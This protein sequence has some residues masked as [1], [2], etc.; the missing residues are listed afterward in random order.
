MGDNNLLPSD[1]MKDFQNLAKTNKW[2]RLCLAGGIGTAAYFAL[3]YAVEAS[4]NLLQLSINLG[5]TALIGTAIFVG[6]SFFWSNRGLLKKFQDY[7]SRK[8][9]EGFI[10][11]D[12]IDY[13]KGVIEDFRRYLQILKNAIQKLYKVAETLKMKADD[14]IS[15]AKKDMKSAE[16]EEELG[17]KSKAGLSAYKSMRRTD[18]TQ[19]IVAGYADIEDNIAVMNEVAESVA[20]RIEAMEFDVEMMQLNMEVSSAKSQAAFAA[21]AVFNNKSSEAAKLAFAKNAYKDKVAIGAAQFKQFMGRVKPLLEADRIDKAVTTK[22]GL[23]ALM[24]FKKG[25]D[26]GG[27][28]KFADQL[29]AFKENSDFFNKNKS[30]D[31][32]VMHQKAEVVGANTSG[33]FSNLS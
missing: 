29:K 31:D 16:A 24:Q 20:I 1:G 18:A 12:P 9:W 17:N 30:V 15:L 10:Y 4:G 5:E 14:L 23:D 8:L 25:I 19:E 11:H 21:E 6:V 26:I 7:L 2:V 28:D 27:L 22:E 3:P 32:R 13:I 33:R